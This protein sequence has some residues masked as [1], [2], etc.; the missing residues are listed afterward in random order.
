MKDKLN[1]AYILLCKDDTL[2]TGWTNDL[3]ARI[4]A[5]NA[6]MGAKYTRMRLPV[7]LVHNEVFDTKSEALKREYEIKKLSRQNKLKLIEK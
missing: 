7:K 6:G 4:C 5:H 2:Y 1:Y 3:E